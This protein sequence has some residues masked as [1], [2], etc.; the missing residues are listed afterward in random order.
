MNFDI[1]WNLDIVIYN[2]L[3]FMV[4]EYKKV[5]TETLGEY[6]I[7]IRT[8]RGFTLEGVAKRTNIKIKF[9]QYLETGQLQALPPDVYVVGFLRQLAELY[10]MP[11]DILLAQFKKERDITD[12]V[13]EEPLAKIAART[14]FLSRIVITPK[15]M[16]VGFGLIFVLVTMGYIVWQVVSINSTPSLEVISPQ[17]GAVIKQ[18]Y[19][20]VEGHTEPGTLVT[21]NDQDVFVDN[22]GQFRTTLGVAPGQ[23]ELLFKAKNKFDKVI[24]KSVRVVID[25]TVGRV[26]PQ[27]AGTFDNAQ[28]TLELQFLKDASL[29]ITVD[30]ENQKPQIIAAGVTKVIHA[31]NRILLSTSNAGSIRA[32]LNQKDLGLLGRDGEVL[33]NVSFSPESATIVDRVGKASKP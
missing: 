3:L 23:K 27:V 20:N 17:S 26:E 5:P 19:I 28:V 32:K 18:S 4:F 31:K 14:T 29:T 8:Q 24:T 2:F 22:K 9:L 15:L 16:S 1:V 7:E 33:A 21:I 11:C 10:A 12:H 13:A 30:D 25:T 6:L